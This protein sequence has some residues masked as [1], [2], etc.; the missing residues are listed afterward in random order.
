MNTGT[1]V[2]VSKQPTPAEKNKSKD[3]DGDKPEQPLPKGALDPQ[4]MGLFDPAAFLTPHDEVPMALV[5]RK[6]HGS[7]LLVREL[8]AVDKS[9]NGL[10]ET[11]EPGHGDTFCPQ[12]VA[13][14]T[15]MRY[16]ERDV[17]M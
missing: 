12:D 8:L 15:A 16:A 14:L 6:P 11:I 9:A 1:S 4:A 17:F 3:K 2:A 13:W 5:N 10:C 7:K